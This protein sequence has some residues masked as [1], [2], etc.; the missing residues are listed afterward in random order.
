MDRRFKKIFY[1]FFGS[2]LAIFAISLIF[3][4]EISLLIFINVSFYVASA[5]LFTSLMIYTVNSG[6]FDTMS[7][8]FRAIFASSDENEKKRSIEEITPL[9][10]MVTINTFPVLAIGLFDFILMLAGLFFYYL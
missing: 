1:G 2:Q 4:K 6:F 9:S 8:S 5:M 10:E 7:Y 3:F